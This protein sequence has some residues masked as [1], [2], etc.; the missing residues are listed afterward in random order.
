MDKSKTIIGTKIWFKSADGQKHRGLVE[1]IIPDLGGG[2]F[3]Q[4]NVARWAES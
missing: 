4:S 3:Y 1:D 2:I